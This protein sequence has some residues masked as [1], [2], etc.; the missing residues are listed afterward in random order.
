MPEER[1]SLVGPGGVGGG[2]GLALHRDHPPILPE[3]RHARV[4]S[5]VPE[6]VEPVTRTANDAAPA[7]GWV[8]AGARPEGWRGARSRASPV[9]ARPCCQWAGRTKRKAHQGSWY[10][11]V[12]RALRRE[13]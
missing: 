2:F 6:M 7:P 12:G 3:D 13:V 11:W 5:R 1:R 4:G 9:A 8:G 10:C